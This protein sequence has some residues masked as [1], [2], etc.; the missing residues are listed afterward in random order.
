[1]FAFYDV[2]PDSGYIYTLHPRLIGY[3]KKRCILPAIQIF[4]ASVYAH[5]YI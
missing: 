3:M 1:M 4:Q 5:L 2:L